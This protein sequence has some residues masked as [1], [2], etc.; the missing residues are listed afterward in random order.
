[1]NFENQPSEPVISVIIVNY[2]TPDLS[3]EAV[4]SV[5]AYAPRATTFEVHLLDNASPGDDAALFQKAHAELKWRNKVVLHLESVNHGF[6]SGNNVVLRKLAQ[7][8][9]PPEAVFFLNPDAFLLSGTIDLLFEFL[10]L[11][12]KVAVVGSEIV[13]PDGT[14]VSASFRFPSVWSELSA[15]AQFGPVSRMLRHFMVPLP[16][17]IRTEQVDWV[18]GASFMARLEVIRDANFFDPRFF[19]YYEEIDLMRRISERGWQIWHL[20]D[21]PVVHV[22]GASTGM[23]EG[24]TR[25]GRL[26]RY[27]YESWRRYF[28]KRHG[29]AGASIVALARLLGWSVDV[30]TSSLRGKPPA[31]PQYFFRDFTSVVMRPLL[32]EKHR[33]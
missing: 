6:G 9:N 17:N 3:I 5:L 12:P 24:R 18:S 25:S 27:W 29:R 11:H 22:A 4:Q 23:N 10:K 26:P 8:K 20:A 1:M 30:L 7:R 15:G 16:T 14:T 19:L 21:S 33:D 32:T 2:G 28:V 13:R 31:A